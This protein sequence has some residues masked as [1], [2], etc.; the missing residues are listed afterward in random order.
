VFGLDPRICGDP[1]P[2]RYAVTRCRRDGCFQAHLAVIRLDRPVAV[3]RRG[4]R[5]LPSGEGNPQSSHHPS[6][7]VSPSPWRDGS[8]PSWGG[9]PLGG[10]ERNR[11]C[12]GTP[13]AHSSVAVEPY[14]SLRVVSLLTHDLVARSP[15]PYRVGEWGRSLPPH[16]PSQR[17]AEIGPTRCCTLCECLPSDSPHRRW[18]GGEGNGR[19]PPAGGFAVNQLSPSS[20]SISQLALPRPRL[21]QQPTVRS[22]R[23]GD[24]ERARSP[25]F[26][27]YPED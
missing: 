2:H 21:L 7:R 11:G 27:S 24:L 6:Q 19:F 17:E 26:G 25:G 15:T 9:A 23:V 22:S 13:S 3:R 14:P 20:I 8:L 4:A 12:G 5:S 1:P 18:E 16:S 10:W